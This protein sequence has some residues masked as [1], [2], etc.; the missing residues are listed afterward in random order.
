MRDDALLRAG[1]SG[2]TSKLTLQGGLRFDRA[3]ELGARRSRK[4]PSAFLPTPLIFPETPGV[5]SYKD[6][7]PR[8][9]AT[10]DLFGNGKTA[11]KANVGKYLEATIT[12]SNYG[13]ANPTSRIIAERHAQLDRRQ[14]QL[15]RRLRSAEPG[16]RRISARSGGDV[17]GAFSNRELRQERVQ[18][19][20]RSGDSER[21]GRPSVRLGVRRLGAAGSAAARVDRSRLRPPLV[22]GLPRDRQP[23]G[24][25]VRLR[26]SSAS[27][28]R[29]I[30]ACRAAAATRSSGLYDVNPALFGVT[31]NYITSSDNYGTQYQRFNGLDITRTPGS[32]NGLT[33]QGGFS[34]GKTTSDNCEIRAKLPETVA[35]QPVLPRRDGLPAAVQGA[36]QLHDPEDRRA[37]RA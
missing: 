14:R 1:D 9:A 34:V 7:T 32:R 27:S 11:I 20:D 6:I 3:V 18:Q 17:C 37:D 15:R 19:H 2:R 22:P 28:R 5:D 16:A 10:Y 30:R 33:I 26:A 12:A 25:A 23:R 29:S 24:D 35:A 4:G 36:R 31:N 13:I 21:L 8:V